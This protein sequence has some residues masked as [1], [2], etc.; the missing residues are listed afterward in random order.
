MVSEMK[1][2]NGRIETTSILCFHF[3]HLSQR[4]YEKYRCE[5][6]VYLYVNFVTRALSLDAQKHQFSLVR[7]HV[8]VY[9]FRNLYF[10]LNP[11]DQIQTGTRH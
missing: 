5:K 3:M 10:A 7:L 4:T 2:E 1:H 6:N 9:D 11:M 8:L